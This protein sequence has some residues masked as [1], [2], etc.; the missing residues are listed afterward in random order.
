MD[1]SEFKTDFWTEIKTTAESDGEGSSAA[2]VKTAVQYLIDADVLSE[3]IPSFFSGVGKRNR[4]LCID[5]YFYV[6]K[7]QTL[8]LLN[9]DD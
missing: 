1:F 6:E 3:L 2:F 7:D 5:G 4:R 9:L 8:I